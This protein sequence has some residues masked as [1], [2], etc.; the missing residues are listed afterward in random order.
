VAER[1]LEHRVHL[2]R[3]EDAVGPLGRVAHLQLTTEDPIGKAIKAGNTWLT[4]VGV[5]DDRSV[6]KET[7]E[8]LGVR[9]PNMDVYVPIHTMLLRY[10]NRAQVTQRDVE[11]AARNDN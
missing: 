8:R 2:D 1:L 7:S 10:R 9:D 11:T 6:T 5:L 3:H 4:V